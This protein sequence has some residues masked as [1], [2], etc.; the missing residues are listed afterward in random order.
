MPPLHRISRAYGVNRGVVAAL[1]L[2]S[3]LGS[4]KAAVADIAII[5][6]DQIISSIKT[7]QSKNS[8]VLVNMT[9]IAMPLGLLCGT[10][11]STFW[12]IDSHGARWT[13]HDGDL[14]LASPGAALPLD[15]PAI[16]QGPDIYLPLRTVATLAGLH[17]SMDGS[18]SRATLESDAPA[19]ADFQTFEIPKTTAEL[20]RDK[21][22]DG[23]A[24]VSNV[25]ARTEP[26]ALPPSHNAMRLGMGIGY[27]QGA[28]AG[29]TLS[30]DG[31][32]GASH[33][34]FNVF[35]TEGS[36]GLRY[37]SGQAVFQNEDRSARIEIG[38]MQSELWGART[39]L[40][41]AALGGG[42][43]SNISLYLPSANSRKLSL[44][45]SAEARLSRHL[46][47]GGEVATDGAIYVKNRYVSGPLQVYS[48]LRLMRDPG[49]CGRGM[50]LSYS[51]ARGASVS[52]GVSH[53]G[54]GGNRSDWQSI[55][56]R[57]PIS[58]TISLT[59]NRNVTAQSTG[60]TTV[61]GLGV[62]I[63]FQRMQLS[64]GYQWGD[65]ASA[66]S[67]VT[68][69]SRQRAMTLA[70]G[71]PV[72]ARAR[73]DYQMSTRWQDDGSAAQ[74]GQLLSALR[75][76]K[77]TD[78]Q[79][80]SGFPN[81]ADESLL[82]FRL[83][84]TLSADQSLSVEYGRLQPYQSQDQPAGD[85]GF[86][87]M[88]HRSWEA[89][90]AAAGGTVR[91][92]ALD[93]LGKPARSVKVC[94]GQYHQR[95]DARGRF[96]FKKVP[97]GTYD[98]SIDPSSVAANYQGPIDRV[99]VEVTGKADVRHDFRIVPLSSVN[100]RVFE[101]RNRNGR[102]DAG[103][104]VCNVVLG[105][106]GALTLTDA[107]GKY[108]FYNIEPGQ[109]KVVLDLS[110]LPAELAP[111]SSTVVPFTLKP[112]QGVDNADFALV[113]REKTVEFQSLP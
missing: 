90:T 47:V 91:G 99:A 43:W 87:F 93:L 12:V 72:N 23:G 69:T 22:R 61:N 18:G 10:D 64:A 62:A 66:H 37:V 76:A 56:M 113:H 104:G 36:A 21:R 15:A 16:V 97:A 31:L 27:V 67:T 59:L 70:L 85:R 2:A 88:F 75:L 26:A 46:T 9:P 30:G 54:A 57:V 106:A 1:T 74:T 73:F 34:N 50:S 3:V 35:S 51:F 79:I 13:G 92:Q 82:R 86:Q 103:E 111:S 65:T 38:G 58:K 96:E 101:D 17:L 63:P 14:S 11:N 32:V 55:A 102:F 89:H 112:D 29:I 98:L 107:D 109:G 45:Y 95:T 78:F 83:V 42:R 60:V 68:A 5:F 28:D 24:A 94:L 20:A 105:L 77:A 100:G 71:V 39:G 108:S 110:R 4:G 52:V 44:A 25:P 33:V 19:A 6:N 80:V 49:A 41:V 40:R 48:Y 53:S 84:R 8:S 81:L 7:E